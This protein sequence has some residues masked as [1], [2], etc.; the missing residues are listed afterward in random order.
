VNKNTVLAFSLILLTLLFFNSPFYNKMYEKILKKERHTHQISNNQKENSTPSLLKD[1]VIKKDTVYIKENEGSY[2]TVEKPR[3]IP[4]ND[5]IAK[6]QP[7][8]DTLWIE[9]D[10]YLCGISEIGAKIIS[11]KM[12]NYYYAAN[13]QSKDSIRNYIDLVANSEL[14]GGNLMINGQ[15]YDGKKFVRQIKEKRILLSKSENKT[16]DFLYSGEGKNEI[17]KRY[18]FFG[19]SYKIGINII[20]SA[21]DGKSIVVGWK[22]GIGE[23]ENQ[24]TNGKSAAGVSEP[25]KVHAYDTKNVSHF[26]LKKVEKDEESGFY[27]WAA[28]T[29]KYFMIALVAD[30]I[31]NA[32]LLIESSDA[33]TVDKDGKRGAVSLNYGIQIRRS[34][35]GNKE[36]FWIY[37]GP[38]KYKLI[39]SYKEKFEKVLF[40]GWEWL[41]RADLWFPFICE[42][43]LWLLI[44]INGFIKDYGITI[45]I[46]TI[47]TRVITY[48]LSQ[49]SMKSMSRMKDIQPKINHIRER[50]KTNP[51]KMNEEVMA[52]YKQE[53]VNPFNP[54]CLPMFLQMP[55]LFALF[56]VL[57]KAIELRGAHTVLIPWVH[58]LSQ[59]ESLFSLT[60]I[61]PNGIPMYGSSVALLPILMAIL[62]FFQNKMTIKDPNQ[63]MMIYFMP[64]FMLVLFNN[65]PAGLVLYWTFSNAL[66]I[67]QQYMLEKSLKAKS[68]PVTIQNIPNQ[69]TKSGKKR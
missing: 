42:I 12:K 19:D 66:G 4:K 20:N 2:K 60:S 3:M 28:I 49:S 16:I 9:N 51:K 41:L 62:T 43:T 68:I 52:L 24:A 53:G 10:K 65:F 27:K 59:P 32:D 61:F 31:K 5:S 40:G 45:L 50:Y 54:G 48:P 30:T 11:L 18:E 67:L 35:E 69:K 15:D 37:A 34:G 55:I 57:R 47:L 64:V 22:A 56:I 6:M 58:D 13:A 21:L 1:G 39:N 44:S 8:G 46:L 36:G 38:S 7:I 17:V 26:Q 33:T 29:S 14:G 23:S 25:R 63:K